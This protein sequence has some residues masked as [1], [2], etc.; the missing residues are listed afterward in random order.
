MEMR[1]GKTGPSAENVTV[2]PGRAAPAPAAPKRSLTWVHER[3]PTR[4]ET[5]F[6][7]APFSSRTPKPAQTGDGWGL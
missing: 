6:L 1:K 2:E 5:V 7:V 4:T 3:A